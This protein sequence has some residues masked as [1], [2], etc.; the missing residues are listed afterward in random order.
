MDIGLLFQMIIAALSAVL[1]YTFIG[2][3]PGT[4]ETSVL[5]PVTL[6][7]ALAG[8]PP[9]VVLT[10]FIAAIVTLNL[11]NM[12]PAALVGLPGGVLS[13]P[14]IEHTL[15]LKN[16]GLS[17][18]TIKKMGAGS[19]IGTVISIPAALLLAN[20]LTPFAEIIQPY[21]S[22]LFVVGAVFLSLIGKHKLLA[23]IS[24]VPLAILFQSLR[25]LYWSAGVV[26]QETNVTTS[27][28][29]G[30]T[31]GPLIISLLSLLN[32]EKRTD[33]LT[34]QYKKIVIPKNLNRQKTLNP[35]KILTKNELKSVSSAALI[36]NFLFVLSPVGLIILLGETVA[37]RKKDAVEKA[38]AA[39]A[40]M[41]ALAQSTYLS[42]III[43]LIALG[44]PLSPVSIGPGNA[45]FN[46]PP[47]YTIDHNLHHLLS[48]GQSAGAIILGA[49]IALSITYVVTNRYAGNI[50]LFV[51][52]RIPHEAILGIFISFILLLAYMDAGLINIFGVLLI[53]IT[54]GTLNKMGVN[55][56][57]Q[58]M[59]LYA[60]PWLVE[61]LAGF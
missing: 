41:S 9:V 35:F 14:V 55:Y 33:M 51:L 3:I 30:I 31:I 43:P 10:F 23:L 54:C 56:G 46:A 6:A 18:V 7:V 42:G 57:I 37:N 58:F 48:W 4:D 60:A 44:I 50:S 40:T 36:S 24:I 38:S 2:F 13:S 12:M 16:A 59:T 53:G 47:V 21:A 15:Y 25:S 49:L 1:L 27:F 8:T 52:R 45:L 26:P 20:L 22:L 28:F 61:K 39:A 34:D 19:L 32:K 17:E 11:T 29:L 5:M